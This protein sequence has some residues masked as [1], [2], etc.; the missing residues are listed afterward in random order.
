MIYIAIVTKIL[1]KQT[2]DHVEEFVVLFIIHYFIHIDIVKIIKII[3]QKIDIL[4]L[5]K[6]NQ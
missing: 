4:D 2:I 1:I 3:I 5:K 6:N